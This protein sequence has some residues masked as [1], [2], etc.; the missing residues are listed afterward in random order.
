MMKKEGKFLGGCW[1]AKSLY[2]GRFSRGPSHV[3]SMMASHRRVSIFESCT[4]SMP[5][6]QRQRLRLEKPMRSVGQKMVS[7]CSSDLHSRNR[8]AQDGLQDRASRGSVVQRGKSRIGVP[9]CLRPWTRRAAS[10]LAWRDHREGG[11]EP[12]RI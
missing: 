7:L 8:C 5:W 12:V 10:L 1:R 4:T 3:Y 6:H 2:F 9:I 11:L